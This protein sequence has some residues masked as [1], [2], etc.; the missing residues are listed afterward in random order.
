MP[1]KKRQH[2]ESELESFLFG[3]SLTDDKESDE[4]SVQKAP[5]IKAQQVWRDDD[6][7][8]VRVDLGAVDRL[9]KFRPATASSAVTGS[10]LTS[11]MQQ[12]FGVRIVHCCM[13]S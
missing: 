8:E 5:E 1:S 12:R 11:L 3:S 9:K 4:R 6:D 10:E 2:C 13:I 7:D